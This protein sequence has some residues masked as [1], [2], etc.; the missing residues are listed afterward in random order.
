MLI[1]PG[2]VVTGALVNAI[3]VV[4]RQM[5]KAVAGVRKWDDVATARWFETFRL[6]G[7]LPDHPH[8]V[9]GPIAP[10]SGWLNVGYAE[11]AAPGG[12]A[13]TPR[14]GSWFCCRG[15]RPRP[16]EARGLLVRQ[17]FPIR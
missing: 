10:E 11:A 5:S 12:T 9:A 2:E 14:R 4:G 3:A 16:K 15:R 7:T 13:V 1:I 6:S 17:P 8:G